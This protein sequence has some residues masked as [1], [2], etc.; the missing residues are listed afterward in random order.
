MHDVGYL[1]PGIGEK[2]TLETRED[3]KLVE[4]ARSALLAGESSRH[5]AHAATTLVF[6][7]GPLARPNGGVDFDVFAGSPAER[8]GCPTRRG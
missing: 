7:A 1:A 5:F 6:E 3:A 8:A 4:T 2:L